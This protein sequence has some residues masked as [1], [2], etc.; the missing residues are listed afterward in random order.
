MSQETKVNAKYV[1]LQKM[2]AFLNDKF[3]GAYRVNVCIKCLFIQDDAT[4]FDT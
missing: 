3:G 2:E 1:N 4:D